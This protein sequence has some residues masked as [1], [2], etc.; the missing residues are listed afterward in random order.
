MIKRKFPY[1]LIKK[2][3]FG[4]NNSL[5]YEEIG[6]SRMIFMGFLAPEWP[7][8]YVLLSFVDLDILVIIVD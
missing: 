6:T 5:V 2:S 7:Y 3:I 4:L 1:G 8:E